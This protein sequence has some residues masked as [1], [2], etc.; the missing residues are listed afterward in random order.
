MKSWRQQFPAWSPQVPCGKI[1]S[2]IIIQ[3]SEPT[4]NW[5]SYPNL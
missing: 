5:F 1:H 2:Y 4:S 3:I